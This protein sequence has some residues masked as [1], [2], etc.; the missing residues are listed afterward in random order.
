MREYR[1]A[2]MQINLKNLASDKL[3]RLINQY[4]IGTNGTRIYTVCVKL[5]S[6]TI[7]TSINI[8]INEN[9][10]NKYIYIFYA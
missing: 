2:G 8:T 3:W 7:I 10:L 5:H 4:C 6:V 9:K 1:P